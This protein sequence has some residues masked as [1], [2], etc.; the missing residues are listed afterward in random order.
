MPAEVTAREGRPELSAARLGLGAVLL[1][2]IISAL[3]G[4]NPTAV[5][6]ALRGFPPIGSAGLR[7][8]I[9]AFG[10]W[11]WCRATGVRL[12][13]RS[14]EGVWLALAGA[15]FLAQI[16]SFTLGVHW[17]TAS[18]SIVLLHTYPFFVVLLAHFLIPEE[19]ASAGRVIGVIAAF[20]GIVIL[21]LGEWGKWEGTQ[22]LGDSVQVGSAFILGAEVVFLKYAVA[23]I[24]PSRVVLWQMV[25]GATGFLAYSV[26]FEGL[27]GA[28]PGMDSVA[29]VAYQGMVIGAFCFSV[30]MWLLRRHAASRVAIFGFVGP[31]VGVTLSALAL[32]EPFTPALALSAACVAAGIVL[33]NLW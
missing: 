13:P 24:D 7:F 5:K 18:H 28:R 16:G 19:R 25:I 17:G 21:F 8:A 10:V 26:G 15:F 30:W 27:A 6:I 2:G 32:G 20:S 1:A 12:R 31:L 3:W 29:A 33:A 11:I 22:L 9:A 4:T 23:R 14:G